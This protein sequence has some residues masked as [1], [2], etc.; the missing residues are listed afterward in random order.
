MDP[1]QLKRFLEA[2][3]GDHDLAGVS[4][5]VAGG[6]DATAV[7]AYIPGILKDFP[8]ISWDA[9]G[10]LH[11]TADGRLDMDA[12]KAYLTASAEALRLI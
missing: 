9:E 2:A 6:L 1:D 5:G 10:K 7:Q 3:F 12:A 8:Q 4:F 11:Q